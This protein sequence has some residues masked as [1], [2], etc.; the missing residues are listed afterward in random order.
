MNRVQ[1]R[2]QW[3]ST[4]MIIGRT[5]SITNARPREIDEACKS[6]VMISTPF[7]FDA[8]CI[9]KKNY[10]FRW[11]VIIEDCFAP[12]WLVQTDFFFKGHCRTVIFSLKKK[13]KTVND[14]L[15]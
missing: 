9:D 11:C 10:T 4:L 2:T 7:R 15:L 5:L 1:D 14:T 8:I 12:C 3:D 13:K 6:P